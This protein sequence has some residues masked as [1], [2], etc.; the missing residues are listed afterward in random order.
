MYV[1]MKYLTNIGDMSEYYAENLYDEEW[2][3]PV[4]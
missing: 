4:N 3:S 2:G 1:A